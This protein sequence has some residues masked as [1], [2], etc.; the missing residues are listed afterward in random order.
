V[1]ASLRRQIVAPSLPGPEGTAVPGAP[2]LDPDEDMHRRLPFL[3]VLMR[4][5]GRRI[6][7]I[8]A[9]PKALARV[10]AGEA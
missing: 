10:I 2:R 7:D 6:E 8:L 9:H 3:A 4:E 5:Y 1:A